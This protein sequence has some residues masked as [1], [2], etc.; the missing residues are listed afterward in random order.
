MEI[1]M[2]SKMD[3]EMAEKMVE[4]KVVLMADLMVVGKDGWMGPLKVG[5]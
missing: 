2:V 3:S 1:E 5:R 4:N